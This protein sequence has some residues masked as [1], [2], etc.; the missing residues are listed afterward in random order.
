MLTSALVIAIIT[1][2]S[3]I[4]LYFSAPKSADHEEYVPDGR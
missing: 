4:E 2:P 1:A 3:A